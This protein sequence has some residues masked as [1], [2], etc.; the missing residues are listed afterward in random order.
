MVPWLTELEHITPPSFR[1]LSRTLPPLEEKIAHLLSADPF[2]DDPDADGDLEHDKMDIVGSPKKTTPGAS[3][4]AKK[5][6][7]VL[8]DPGVSALRVISSHFID[9]AV[10]SAIDVSN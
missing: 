5:G 3:A 4:A 6:A 9:N 7:W 2:D 1:R 10:F 8:T